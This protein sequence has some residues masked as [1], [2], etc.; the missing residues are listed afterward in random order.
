[1]W[2]SRNAVV[3]GQDQDEVRR[4]QLHQLKMEVTQEYRRYHKDPFIISREQSRL[5]DS[6]TMHQRLLQDRDT[7]KCW[8]ADVQE[9]KQVQIEQRRKAAEATVDLRHP[10]TQRIQVHATI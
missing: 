10:S 2:E 4:K 9:A 3:H 6:R 5:F 7:L 8:L 1:M